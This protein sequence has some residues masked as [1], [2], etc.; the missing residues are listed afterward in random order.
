[1]IPVPAG[2]VGRVVF[3]MLG[4]ALNGVATAAYIGVQLGLG[5]RDGLMTGLRGALAAR[6]GS[7]AR[8]SRSPWSPPAGCWAAPGGRYPA[9]RGHDRTLV[10]VLLPRLEIAPPEPTRR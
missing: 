2:L 7:S 4:I 10:H 1:M 9:L 8:P 6:S 3:G 5:P